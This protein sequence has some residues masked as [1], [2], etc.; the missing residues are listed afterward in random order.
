[1]QKI[2]NPNTTNWKLGIGHTPQSSDPKSLLDLCLA[3]SSE[4]QHMVQ[5]K[6]HDNSAVTNTYKETKPNQD[7]LQMPLYADNC[8]AN[9]WLWKK[10]KFNFK[11]RWR[12]TCFYSLF[13]LFITY[14]IHSD[15]SLWKEVVY[16]MGVSKF[17]IVSTNRLLLPSK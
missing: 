2:M 3:H 9:Y 17:I 12:F 14:L 10:R 1:M 4:T 16:K 15:F 7:L 5:I 13:F 11:K 6:Q 8:S